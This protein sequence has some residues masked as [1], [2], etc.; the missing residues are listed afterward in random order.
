MKSADVQ[1]KAFVDCSV[2]TTFPDSAVNTVG[3]F[4][5]GRTSRVDVAITNKEP[6]KITVNFIGGVFQDIAT[7]KPVHNVPPHSHYPLH[8]RMRN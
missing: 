6:Q 5:N 7:L 8:C 2:R 4:F 3:T 1:S